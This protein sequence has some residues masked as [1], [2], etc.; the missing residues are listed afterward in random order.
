MAPKASRCFD[1]NLLLELCCS[2]GSDLLTPAS[3]AGSS[4]GGVA[5]RVLEF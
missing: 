1:K 4:F 3:G 5:F 2:V